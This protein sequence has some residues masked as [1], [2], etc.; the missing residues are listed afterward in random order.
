MK[1]CKE[2]LHYIVNEYPYIQDT[3]NA[4]DYTYLSYFSE[5]KQNNQLIHCH[6]NYRSEGPWYDWVMIRWEPNDKITQAKENWKNVMFNIVNMKKQN[7]LITYILLVKCY[8]LLLQDQELIMLLLNAVIIISRRV[9]S[10][11]LYG[12]KN[13]LLHQKGRENPLYVT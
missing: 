8:A 11:Q 5:Y 4:G 13:I 9:L 7:I 3:V 12:N 1:L 6:Y 10:F 2:A